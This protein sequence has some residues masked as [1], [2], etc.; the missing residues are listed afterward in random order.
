MALYRFLF[1]PVLLAVAVAAGDVGGEPA[2]APPP[3]AVRE[4]PVAV[5]PAPAGAPG[6]QIEAAPASTGPDATR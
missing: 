5:P 2:A 4:A 6:A 3:A 1:A